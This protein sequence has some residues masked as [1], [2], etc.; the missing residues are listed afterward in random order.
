MSH[1]DIYA[2]DSTPI[3]DVNFDHLIKVYNFFHYLLFFFPLIVD[4]KK[5]MGRHFKMMYKAYS[6]SEFSPH[7]SHIAE[8]SHN[9]SLLWWLQK[10]DFSSSSIPFTCTS[11]YSAFYLSKALPSFLVIY[12]P[13]CYHNELKDSYFLKDL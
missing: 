7:L 8:S 3:S 11:H 12:F 10:D 5:S 13:T 9:E 4:R 1:P 6:S 2:V